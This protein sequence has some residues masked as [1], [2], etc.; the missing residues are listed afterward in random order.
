ML[1]TDPIYTYTA[2]D[3][4]PLVQFHVSIAFNVPYFCQARRPDQPVSLKDDRRPT[5]G[6]WAVRTS[7]GFSEFRLQ[8]PFI[9][10]GLIPVG[11]LYDEAFF[12]LIGSYW[13]FVL[14]LSL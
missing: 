10:P 3:R 6:L 14:D 2:L 7:L 1:P 11:L 4:A 9:T 12:F 8:A 13:D 5:W